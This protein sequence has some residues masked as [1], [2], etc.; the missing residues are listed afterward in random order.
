MRDTCNWSFYRKIL[1]GKISETTYDFDI[2][3]RIVTQLKERLPELSTFER[4][5]LPDS[6]TIAMSAYGNAATTLNALGALFQSATGDFELIL[7]DDCS[8]DQGEIRQVFA[9][10]R[11]Q[12]K[13]TRI[14][15][16]E[17]NLEYSG[18][19]NAILSH[20]QG[21]WILFLSNDIFV[22][23]SYLRELLFLANTA[24]K[25]G[26]IRGVANFVDNNGLSTH[27]IPGCETVN[28]Y[29]TL[30][31]F[32]EKIEREYKSKFL[33]DSFLTGDAF[34]VRRAVLDKIGTFDPLFFGYFADHDFGIRARI[35][36]FELLLAQGAFAFHH[37]YVNIDYLSPEQRE[38]KALTR[39][40]RIHEN[41]A[42]FKLKYTLPVAAPY[43]SINS[44]PWDTL[45]GV[46][47]D[48][49]RH[50]SAPQN[51]GKFESSN[52]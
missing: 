12:H 3:E 6:L 15:T 50:Y 48:P 33:V 44:I 27:N 25:A 19:L 23:P 31:Q 45:S 29:L 24:P 46:P 13:R 28:N 43:I 36:G 22:T 26:I 17:E 7:V 41:W 40:A 51:Y 30:F 10:V 21:E 5:L 1:L 4:V 42:R 34:M 18:S 37:Q 11:A 20:A 39:W 35:A 38:K 16:F 49:S 2:Q 47:F 32:G 9:E 14:F 8:P 52:T